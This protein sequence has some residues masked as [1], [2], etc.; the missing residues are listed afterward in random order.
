MPANESRNPYLRRE[1]ELRESSIRAGEARRAYDEIAEIR[2]EATATS[3]AES[4]AR[5]EAMIYHARTNFT[6]NSRGNPVFTSDSV[7]DPVSSAPS[8][9]AHFQ[10]DEW[11]YEE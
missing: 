1:Q 4:N 6:I 7:P 9:V 10:E 11:E 8:P 5:I 2:G 3:V